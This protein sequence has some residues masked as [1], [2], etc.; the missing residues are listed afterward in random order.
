M[1]EALMRK[2]LLMFFIL[3]VL[4]TFLAVDSTIGAPIPM[5]PSVLAV[6]GVIN[7]TEPT[8][9]PPPP[10]DP[11]PPPPPPTNPPSTSGGNFSHMDTFD[12]AG[13][14]LAGW[15]DA[16]RAAYL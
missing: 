13:R 10:T 12:Q 15:S 3:H 2:L 7:P 8:P 11:T 5:P 16:D 6:D 1:E 4:G 14:W 9:P